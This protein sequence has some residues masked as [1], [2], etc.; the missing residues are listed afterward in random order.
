LATIADSKSF[1]SI[2]M[3]A[4]NE[5]R[6]ISAAIA[7]I[8]PRSPEVQFEL[9]VIDG[10]STDRTREIVQA[11]AASDPRVRLI[12]NEKKIQSAAVNLGARVADARAQYL[13]RADCHMS[14]PE[15]FVA[16]CVNQLAAMRVSSVVVPMRAEGTTCLQRAI[17]AAQNSRLGNGGSAH[18][19]SGQSG[20]VEHGH[21]AGFDRR[22]FLDL[23]GYD[24]RFTHNED[25]EFDKRLVQ[26]GRHIYLDAEAMLTY[27]PRSDF[28]S[29]ARQYFKHGAGRAST[30]LKHRSVPGIRQMLPVAALLACLIS[31]PLAIVH[32]VFLA[33]P[34]SYVGLCVAWGLVLA[35]QQ[36]QACLALSGPAAVIMH[37]SWAVGFV[38]KM[39]RQLSHK[40]AR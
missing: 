38:Q 18:R 33:V 4:L 39:A 28:V 2:I 35:A 31:L 9:L 32:P 14:Y 24:E 11:A 8:I 17:A 10:G 13:V 15:G 19:R 21:H 36:R 34:A 23:G 37:M 27:Y 16:R 6:Y 20:L 22:V 3:P 30:L 1:V 12:F 29:L 25:A 5:E 7:S 40:R 26:S